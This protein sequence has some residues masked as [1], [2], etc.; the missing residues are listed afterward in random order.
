[1]SP[2]PVK[3]TKSR[4][5]L[6]PL[7]EQQQNVVENH[8]NA[9]SHTNHT[10]ENAFVP[11]SENYGSD[12]NKYSD[13]QRIHRAVPTSPLQSRVLRNTENLQS[14]L[15][16]PTYRGFDMEGIKP[17]LENEDCMYGPQ[18]SLRAGFGSPDPPYLPLQ[19][20]EVILGMNFPNME[21]NAIGTTGNPPDQL[22]EEDQAENEA[23]WNVPAPLHSHA[24]VQISKNEHISEGY[25]QEQLSKVVLSLPESQSLSS[26]IQENQETVADDRSPQSEKSPQNEET[27]RMRQPKKRWLHEVRLEQGQLDKPRQPP[28]IENQNRPSVVVKASQCP[29]NPVMPSSGA[30]ETKKWMGAMALIQLA[31]VPEE[32]SQPLNLSTPKYTAL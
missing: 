2:P 1:M 18:A 32:G 17:L 24:T 9:V 31:E 20:P 8:P 14:P 7:M 3:R 23:L 16:T 27:W 15:K 13:N 25:H 30:G 12:E 19:E 5:G 10:D 26:C 21:F 11:H 4:R 6:G 28:D 29:M 22:L